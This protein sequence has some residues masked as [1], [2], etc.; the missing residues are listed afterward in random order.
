MTEMNDDWTDDERAI[1]R[2]RAEAVARR[3]GARVVKTEPAIFFRAGRQRCCAFAATVRAAVRLEGLVPIPRAGRTVAG[4]IARGGEVIPVFHLAGVLGHRIDRLPET[5]HA[6]LLGA[7]TDEVAV[8]VD[9]LERFG[10]I[11]PSELGDAPEEA[12]SPYVSAATPSG[13]VLVDL[14]SLAASDLLWVEQ[15]SSTKTGRERVR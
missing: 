7:T 1:L 2:A 11:D 4:A 14:S 3:D 10:E 8:A 9:D 5:A 12:R 13:D 6:L 15:G